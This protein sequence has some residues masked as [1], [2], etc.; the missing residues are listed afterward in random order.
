VT[1]A[2]AFAT[3]RHALDEAGLGDAAAPITQRA[4]NR[5]GGQPNQLRQR[6]EGSQRKNTVR[7]QEHHDA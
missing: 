6:C 7:I 2:N 1:T 4:D 3:I 5:P